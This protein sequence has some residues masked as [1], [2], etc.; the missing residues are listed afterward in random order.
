M[1]QGVPDALLHV[2]IYRKWAR[3]EK[4]S[5]KKTFDHQED[6]VPLE[7]PLLAGAATRQQVEKRF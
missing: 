1:E 6:K 2:A 7:L 4:S 5:P 3:K